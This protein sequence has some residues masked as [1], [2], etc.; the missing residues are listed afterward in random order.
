M[1]S[2]KRSLL[3]TIAALFVSSY[4]FML[5][6]FITASGPGDSVHPLVIIE[7]AVFYAGLIVGYVFFFMASKQRK[8][9]SKS[10]RSAAGRP[11]LLTFFSSTPA[12]VFDVVFVLSLIMTVISVATGERMPDVL[13]Y[14]FI[15]T[16]IFSAQMRA[17]VNGI[18]FRTIFSMAG[19][20]GKRIREES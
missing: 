19:V 1:R 17:I 13:I 2:A 15:S 10:E 20:R 5:S 18:N 7:G 14:F 9:S 12:A 16:L 4:V 11:G 6:P 8:K 3:V